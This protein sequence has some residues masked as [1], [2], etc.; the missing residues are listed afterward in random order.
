M[1][2]STPRPAAQRSQRRSP[3][4]CSKVEGAL[5]EKIPL[6]AVCFQSIL[7]LPSEQDLDMS[8]YS[9]VGAGELQDP[10]GLQ[11]WVLLCIPCPLPSDLPPF[12]PSCRLSGL[13][14][15]CWTHWCSSTPLPAL[16][17]S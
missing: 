14:M 3:C 1:G 7:L 4:F 17:R 5:E 2:R 8:L 9:K 13:W 11:E 10:P 16:E 6:F 12:C 15:R